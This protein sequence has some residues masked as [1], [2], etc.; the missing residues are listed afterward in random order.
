ML[1][2]CDYPA[3]RLDILVFSDEPRASHSSKEGTAP[4]VRTLPLSE[5]PSGPFPVP[6]ERVLSTAEGEVLLNMPA[7]GEVSSEWIRSMV[8]HCTAQTPVVVGPT[9]IEHEDLFLPRLQALSHLGRLAWTA[10]SFQFPLPVSCPTSNWA[11]RF[12]WLTHHDDPASFW[13]RTF[14]HG[15]LQFTPDKEAVLARSPAATFED[16]FQRLADGFK[17]TF[18][19]SNSSVQ[20][21]G[22][23][24]W[25]LH[26]VLLG[27][28]VVAVALPAWRQPTLLALVALMLT[29]VVLALPAAKHYGQRGLLR[30]IVP[31][32]LM[33]VFTL[34]IAGVWALV[35]SFPEVES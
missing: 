1:E 17:R 14:D 19:A 31:G 9:V 25:L 21:Q 24:L 20:A 34:P 6:L 7:D 3:D 33:L 26:T 28:G 5:T 8:R 15:P 29:N 35:A 27:G 16:V 10:G 4:S 23:G 32:E 18:R 11:A 13:E 30:S 12:D 2:A 22:I